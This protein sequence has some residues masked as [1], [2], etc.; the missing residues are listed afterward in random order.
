[1]LRASRRCIGTHVVG[2]KEARTAKAPWRVADG[3]LTLLV[4]F[5]RHWWCTTQRMLLPSQPCWSYQL[6][7]WR[8]LEYH[9]VPGAQLM[10]RPRS[11]CKGLLVRV[12]EA[13][14]SPMRAFM[15]SCGLRVA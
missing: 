4:W 10:A 3:P 11:T 8:H 5:L 6:H 14:R 7:A 12:T 15:E 13:H 9:R 1:M 2:V